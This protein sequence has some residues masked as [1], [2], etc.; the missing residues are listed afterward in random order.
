METAVNGAEIA[1]WE[2]FEASYNT[3]K[4]HANPFT[5]IEVN[6]MFQQNDKQWIVPAY[7]AGGGKWTVRISPSMQGEYR[8]HIECTDKANVDL[9]GGEQIIRVGAYTGQNALLRHGLLRVSTDKH[10]T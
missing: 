2:V 3:K 7:W 5:A 4:A 6:G 8:L 1:Q 10:R 9:N